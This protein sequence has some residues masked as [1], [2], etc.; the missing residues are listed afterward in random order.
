MSRRTSSVKKKD[1]SAKVVLQQ[2]AEIEVL[3]AQ[4]LALHQQGRLNEAQTIYQPVS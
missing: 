2:S 1:N 4:G 3:I